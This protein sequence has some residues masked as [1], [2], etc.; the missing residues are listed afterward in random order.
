M[1]EKRL[2]A[3]AARDKDREI[4]HSDRDRE[5][6]WLNRKM[7]IRTFFF[8]FSFYIVYIETIYLKYYIKIVEKINNLVTA[9]KNSFFA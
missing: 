9:Y 2:D 6:D 8:Y 5:R 3:L 1:K 7:T 4:A